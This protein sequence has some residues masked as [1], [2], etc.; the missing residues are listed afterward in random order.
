V[1]PFYSDIR[2]IDIYPDSLQDL[3]LYNN[4]EDADYILDQSITFLIL[5]DEYFNYIKIDIRFL[6]NYR[7]IL[8][9]QFYYADGFYKQI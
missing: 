7:L 3:H 1:I 9:T 4:L 6:T 8:Y 5:N 2:T